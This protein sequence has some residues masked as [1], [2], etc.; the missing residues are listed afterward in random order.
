MDVLESKYVLSM[1]LYLDRMSPVLKSD[2]Y[3]DI[4]R[5][6]GMA[7]KIEDLRALGLIEVYCTARTTANV[8]VITDKGRKVADQIRA[9]VDLIDDENSNM[10]NK[11]R[12]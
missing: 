12:R 1:I 2:L 6:S 7:S 3:H 5:G 11:F 8:I 10:D 4:A 9:L